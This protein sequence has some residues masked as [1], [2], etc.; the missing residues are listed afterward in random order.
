MINS[1]KPTETLSVKVGDRRQFRG[2]KAYV[3]DTLQLYEQYHLCG[4]VEY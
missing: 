1:K 3:E 4:F 2:R